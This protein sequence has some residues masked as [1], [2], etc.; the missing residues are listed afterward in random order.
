SPESIS[1]TNHQLKYLPAIKEANEQLA[2]TIEQVMKKGNF[3]LVL[4]GDH[5]LAIGT[6]AGVAKCIEKLGV[7]WFDAHS[8]LNTEKTS[9]SGNIHGMSL[10][11]SLGMGATDLTHIGGF[12]PKILP[13]NTVIIGA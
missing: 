9:P 6:I 12:S 13:E 10:A 5:S 7:I 4:G 8:D 3:P 11:V 1:V 2:Q